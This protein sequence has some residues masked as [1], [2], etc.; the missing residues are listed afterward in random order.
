M[1]FDGIRRAIQDTQE[2]HL[3]NRGATESELAECE[4]ETE[5]LIPAEYQAFLRFSNGAVLYETEELFGTDKPWTMAET[6]AEVVNRLRSSPS[7][8]MP[9]R[10]VPFSAGLQS[11]YW[12]LETEQNG[13]LGQVKV[14]E[15]IEDRGFGQTSYPSFAEWFEV[16]LY[17]PYQHRY[18][19]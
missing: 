19:S 1:T 9:K 4:R 5:L 13:T 12:C 2:A 3:L 8:S 6:I 7:V 18:L 17:R 16:T 14:V 11:R 10:L 15:W